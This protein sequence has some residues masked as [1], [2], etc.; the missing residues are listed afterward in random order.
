MELNLYHRDSKASIHK[1]CCSDFHQ[2]AGWRSVL[3]HFREHVHLAPQHLLT[4]LCDFR[5]PTSSWLTCCEYILSKFRAVFS[6]EETDIFDKQ[7]V[8][9]TRCNAVSIAIVCMM[10]YVH[11]VM[12][13]LTSGPD[14]KTL[15]FVAT[16]L[17][18]YDLKNLA[19]CN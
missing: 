13:S 3:C 17:G 10:V 16:F 14:C 19:F 4:L 6:L 1:K 5:W 8:Q 2:I 7:S 9:E 11:S 15:V 18:N 12:V